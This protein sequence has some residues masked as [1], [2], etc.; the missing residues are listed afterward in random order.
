LNLKFHVGN[1]FASTVGHSL[2]HSPLAGIQ[3]LFFHTPLVYM[4]IW[5]SAIYHD[6]FWWP[7]KGKAI[8]DRV[9]RE[10]VWGQLFDHYQIAADSKSFIPGGA[11]C[12]PHN[13]PDHEVG[14]VAD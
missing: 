5:A 1:N 9:K 4:F 8:Q 13:L 3:K 11:A 6:N 10:T 7:V 2:W 14:R 12:G